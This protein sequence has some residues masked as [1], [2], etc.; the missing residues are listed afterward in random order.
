MI[1]DWL[2]EFVMVVTCEV[3]NDYLPQGVMVARIAV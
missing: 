1:F 3:I 2:E